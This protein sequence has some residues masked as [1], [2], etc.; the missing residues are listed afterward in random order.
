MPPLKA[1]I[2]ALHARKDKSYGAAWK[3]RG[4]RIS[5]LPNIARK[6]DRLV[7][8][9]NSQLE[10]RDESLLDTGI[11]L[12]VYSGKYLLLLAEID[13]GLEKKL[14][15][16]LPRLPL[17]DHSENFDQLI[18][19][20]PFGTADFLALSELIGAIEATFETLWPLADKAST[21]AQRF[22]FAMQLWYQA[23]RMVGVISG[24]EPQVVAE[25]IRKETAENTKGH[26]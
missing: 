22:E 18:D 10:M 2:K 15:L 4:E 19:D 7:V 11:D 23:A 21:S 17:S 26:A 14:P 24:R 3:R 20:V 13:P 25:F 8:Y 5:V 1:A 16:N 12:L 6:V 9:A